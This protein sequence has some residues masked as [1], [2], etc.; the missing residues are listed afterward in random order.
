MTIEAFKDLLN[1]IT[2]TLLRQEGYLDAQAGKPRLSS[3]PAYIAGYE[4]RRTIENT[5]RTSG[6]P[7]GAP[8]WW[9]PGFPQREICLDQ[10]RFGRFGLRSDR[11]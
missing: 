1:P 2:P 5:I 3:N 6:T 7:H 9:K 10:Q 11:Q 4:M 8:G